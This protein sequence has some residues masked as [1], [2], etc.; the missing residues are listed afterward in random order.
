MSVYS[1]VVAGCAVKPV[2]LTLNDI[3][4]RVRHDLA[5]LTH[6]QEPVA[7]PITLYEAMARAL[8]YNLEARVKGLQE[9][10]AHR[11]LD[12][13]HFDML[14]K[15][16]AEGAYAGRS[17]FSGARSRS[18]LSGQTS[19]EPSTSADKNIFTANMTL[20]WD[21]LDFG[22]SYVRAEQAANDVLIA[23]EDKRRTANRVIQEVRTAFWK[24]VG[25]Q[26]A[27]GQLSFLDGWVTKAL[28]EVRAIQARALQTP[29]ASLQY[30][31]ELL[32]AKR[33]IQQ[34][35]EELS[36][37]RRELAELMN[38]APGEPYELLV[39]DSLRRM[40]EIEIPL[41]DLEMRALLSRPELRKVDYQKRINTNET[42][43][44]ILELLPNLNLYLGGN[45]DSNSFLFHNNW[46]SYG[47][48]ISWN[49]LNVFRHPT[50]LQVID[51]QEQVLHAQS[52]AL[53]M[54]IMTQVHVAVAHYHAALQ[55]VN[56]AKR[57]AENQR[58][59]TYQ[60]Q[61]AWSLGRISEHEVIQEKIQNVVAGLRYE[62]AFAN[63]EMAY[64]NVLAAIG[65]DPFP[66]DV[67]SDELE[68]LAKALQD[69]WEELEE[70]TV[71]SDEHTRPRIEEQL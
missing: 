55:D 23:E 35:F 39:P 18:L 64:A 57:Y 71:N 22:L 37:A 14:P 32:G 47:A 63:L 45:Y 58:Q 4:G 40:D 28:Q 70:S 16:V 25:A 65:E 3:Q 62:S 52:L 9:M 17:N 49:L 53:T 31:R 15:V 7:K 66:T 29:L 12:L 20:S 67:T 38:L 43:A 10:V 60:V 41:K 24:A 54:T 19:L 26:R 30:E 42:K 2:P 8:K 36:M 21:V 46:L 56:I 1:L 44:A 5:E 68:V 51:A 6:H 50:R 11:Q 48:K 33:E 34:I 61:R 59:I 69:R 27:L 13:S